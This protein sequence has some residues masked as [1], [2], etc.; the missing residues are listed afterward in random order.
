[1]NNNNVNSEITQSEQVEQFT[2]SE[3]VKKL[4]VFSLPI[5]LSTVINILPTLVS[6]WILARLGKDQ[7]AA[8]GIA[9]PTFYMII[10]L[11]VTGFSAIGIKIGHSFGKNKCHDE[12]GQWVRNGLFLAVLLSIPAVVILLN[13]HF[14]LLWLGQKPHL[15]HIAEPFFSYGALAIIAMLI[16][17]TLNQ[18]FCGVGHPKIGLFMSLITLPLIVALS[19][20]LVLGRIG[21]PQLG[22]GGINCA[23][24]I[25]DSV[26]ALCAVGI[27]LFAKWSKPY[28]VFSLPLGINYHRCS[29]LF[30]LGWPISIQFSGELSSMTAVAYLLGLFGV[31]ALAAAQIVGQYAL[32]FV[33]ISIGLSQAVSILVSQAHGQNNVSHV[34]QLTISGIIITAVIA[35][36][37]AIVFLVFPKT[38]VDFYLKSDHPAHA[39][40]VHIAIYFMMIAALYISFDGVRNMFT[41]TLRGLQDPKVP[42]QI[43]VGCLWLIGFPCAYIAGIAL[44]GGPILLRLCYVIGVIVATVWLA[45]RCNKTISM[46]KMA[47]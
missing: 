9:T 40:L 43:G 34:K 21:F 17:S 41:A 14:L 12:I 33:M 38:L 3:T 16:N 6:I 2:L 29:E 5:I 15:V 27:I 44:H 35:C 20:V 7:L 37:F 13:V 10:T 18:Y 42:M 26:V 28:K 23:A 11:F 25:V 36:V 45:Y 1:M 39:G 4:F 22:L 24:F 47:E 46:L 8:A 19:Y 31:S 32:L 30:K